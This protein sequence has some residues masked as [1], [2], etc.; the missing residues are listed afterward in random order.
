M[1]QAWSGSHVLAGELERARDQLD[2]FL[3]KREA[4]EKKSARKKAR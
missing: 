3:A 2:A 4:E 1:S